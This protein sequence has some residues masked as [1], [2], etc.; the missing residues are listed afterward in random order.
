M[1]LELGVPFL[2]KIPI[3]PQIVISSDE[4]KPFIGT[5][6]DSEASKAFMKIIESIPGAKAP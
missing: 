6:P 3:D 1:A 2:G 5:H 4:G